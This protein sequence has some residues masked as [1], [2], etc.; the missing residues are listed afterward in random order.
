VELHVL[1]YPC[2]E[3]AGWGTRSTACELACAD[4]YL[5]VQCPQTCADL[6]AWC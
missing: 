6:D 5:I 1:S 2:A 3:A 4:T